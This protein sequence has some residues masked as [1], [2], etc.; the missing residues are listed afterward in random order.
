M[1]C[2]INT[3]KYNSN[4]IQVSCFLL[5]FSKTTRIHNYYLTFNYFI[6]LKCYYSICG[7]YCLVLCGL[8]NAAQKNETEP[9][10]NEE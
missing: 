5:T 9:D 6:L 7:Q 1:L 3:G 4:Y 2:H 8:V 10:S